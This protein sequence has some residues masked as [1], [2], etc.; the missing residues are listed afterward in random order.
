MKTIY[1]LRHAKAEVRDEKVPDKARKLVESG[2]EDAGTIAKN[3]R[4]EGFMPE[5][6]LSSDPPRALETA[7]IFAK[8]LKFEGPEIILNEKIYSADDAKSLLQIIKGLDEKY[9]SV[10]MVG[11]DP[12]LSALAH[13]LVKSFTFE[14][15]KAGM[16]GIECK[17]SKWK[18]IVREANQIKLF[19][20]PMKPK[21][22][23]KL[24]YGLTKILGNKIETVIFETMSESNVI[25]ADRIRKMIKK[26]SRQ[27]AE[28]FV[29]THEYP[30]LKTLDEISLFFKLQEMEKV[31]KENK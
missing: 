28:E 22:V 11:H 21:K 19:M 3:L 20:A 1:L 2:I 8:K 15:P 18:D 14:L 30:L 7:K 5:L 13:L 23:E 16:L 24:R 12:S 27:I 17:K 6:I 4:E 31:V 9:S 29:N 25:T 10:M 26:R